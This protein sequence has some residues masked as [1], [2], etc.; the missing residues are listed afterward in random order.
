M[1]EDSFAGTEASYLLRHT[2]H[3][4]HIQIIVFKL[5]KLLFRG[6]CVFSRKTTFALL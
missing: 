4:R 2:L 1:L 6:F 3:Y 5:S